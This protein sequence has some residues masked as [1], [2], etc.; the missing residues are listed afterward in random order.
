MHREFK[1]LLGHAHGESQTVLASFVDI[2]GFSSFSERADPYTTG[3]YISK[4]Y[5]R[6]LTD[7]Y[8]EATFFKPTGDGLMIIEELP[9]DEAGHIIARSVGSALSEQHVTPASW[10]ITL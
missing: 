4:V 8:P 6:V 7:F 3:I 10:P 5:E 1:D 9:R 2:R